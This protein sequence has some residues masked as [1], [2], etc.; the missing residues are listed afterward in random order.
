MSKGWYQGS[1]LGS[2]CSQMDNTHCEECEDH[3]VCNT[4]DTVNGRWME[5]VNQYAS[6]CDCC[7]DLEMHESMRMDPDTQLGYCRACFPTK[8]SPEILRRIEE[9]DASR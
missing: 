1:T 3:G 4:C 6:T 5:A 9:R 7:G 8:L 2:R